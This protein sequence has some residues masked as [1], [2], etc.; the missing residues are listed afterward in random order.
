MKQLDLVPAGDAKDVRK[1]GRWRLCR[2][3]GT[4]TYSTSERCPSASCNPA[5]TEDDL[6]DLFR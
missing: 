3:C 4:W 1:L 2:S 5:E 6:A